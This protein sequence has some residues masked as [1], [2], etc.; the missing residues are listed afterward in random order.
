VTGKKKID[1]SLLKIEE[2]IRALSDAQL[3]NVALSTMIEI[4]GGELKIKI[5]KKHLG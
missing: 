3:K 4:A 1:L 2:P 5:R